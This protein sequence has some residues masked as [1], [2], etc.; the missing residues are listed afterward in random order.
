MIYVL[1]TYLSEQCYDE[2]FKSQ[3]KL[4]SSQFQNRML[5]FRRWQDAQ[6]SVFGRLLLMKGLEEYYNIHLDDSQI[7]YNKFNRPFIKKSYLDFNITHSGV[8]VACAIG[9]KQRAGL[10]IEEV[11]N[12][13]IDDY[14][15]QMTNSEWNKI[16]CANNKIDAF[17]D[18]WTQKE[19]VMKAQGK[20]L[21]IPLKSFQIEDN[22]T[23]IDGYLWYVKGINIDESYKCHIASNQNIDYTVIQI[24]NMRLNV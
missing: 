2:S 15:C 19:A 7:N 8:V 20:G 17:F 9:N 10:D 5:R 4:F 21:S 14:K 3:L 6:A 18:Y 11:K 22:K 24:N 13:K 16:N 1:Y 12:L 23:K